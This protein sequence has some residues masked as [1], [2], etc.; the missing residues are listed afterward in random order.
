MAFAQNALALFGQI[1][2]VF[3]IIAIGLGL[4]QAR[5]LPPDFSATATP[6]LFRAA[7]PVLIFD[8]LI[9]ADYRGAADLRLVFAFAIGLLT[10]I[11]LAWIVT[12]GLGLS[13]TQRAAFA[14]GAIRGN[15]A[16]VSLAVVERVQAPEALSVAALMFAIF[17]PLHHAAS[18]VVLSYA[19]EDHKGILR[20]LVAVFANPLIIAAAAGFLWNVSGLHLPGFI[21][22]TIEILS[23]LA[24][25]LALLSIGAGL[26][27]DV[28]RAGFTI[29]LAGSVIKLLVFP[30]AAVA[31]AFALGVE[32]PPLV[33]L[34]IFAG[35]PTALVSFTI[36]DAMGAD[37]DV[38][39]NM[40]L[41][42]HFGSALTISMLVAGLMTFVT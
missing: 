41:F 23:S 31:T 42:T 20:Q 33:T 15:F 4:R 38:A 32:G 35:A 26:R 36:A 30:V 9:S 21:A 19:S 25:P 22:Q 12:A 7:L 24:L 16:M 17:L 18:I 8:S 34:S 27:I 29:A 5:V 11:G 2:P 3:V 1:A 28:I 40:V 39:S 6:L 13:R 10:A 37:R 14:Q